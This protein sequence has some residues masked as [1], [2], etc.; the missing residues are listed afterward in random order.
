M[1]VRSNWD[2]YSAG[3]QSLAKKKKTSQLGENTGR[4]N[5]QENATKPSL[6][7][8]WRFCCKVLL[9]WQGRQTLE[10]WPGNNSL[11]L[12]LLKSIPMP[13]L[14]G[15]SK[16]QHRLALRIVGSS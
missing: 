2:K 8:Q 3:S 12:F 10:A 13:E 16:N 4:T 9:L 6:T 7:A 15:E 5:L 14:T 11:A 1:Q